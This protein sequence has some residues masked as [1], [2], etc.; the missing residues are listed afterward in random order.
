MRAGLA[1]VLFFCGVAALVATAALVGLEVLT[2]RPEGAHTLQA[3]PALHALIALAG[4]GL[5]IG[6]SW[7]F[8]R[9]RR[10][11]KGPDAGD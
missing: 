2:P 7:L 9:L 1:R 3:T 8:T 11:P 10:D 6:W 5:A 4:A